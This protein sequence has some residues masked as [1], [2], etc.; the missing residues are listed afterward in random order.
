MLTYV[1]VRLKN[2]HL[3]WLI[4]FKN[5]HKYAFVS[6]SLKVKYVFVGVFCHTCT[7]AISKIMPK[8]LFKN[9]TG[10]KAITLIFG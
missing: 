8:T 9:M 5:M 4:I 6:K 7:N 10:K 3:I 2:M 1:K